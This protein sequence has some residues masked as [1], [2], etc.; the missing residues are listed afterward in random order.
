MTWNIT[1]DKLTEN[2]LTIAKA[3]KGKST[4]IFTRE[5]NIKNKQLYTRK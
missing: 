5:N 1:G 3:D 4:V 2:E